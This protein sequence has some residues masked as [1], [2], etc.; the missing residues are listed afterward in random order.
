MEQ[1]STEE[2]LGFQDPLKLEVQVE[3]PANLAESPSTPQFLGQLQ[4]SFVLCLGF[5]SRTSW[6]R[7]MRYDRWV[8]IYGFGLRGSAGAM[9]TF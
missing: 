4:F 3:H 7:F 2:S 8:Y 5:D 9:Q 1:E 6:A